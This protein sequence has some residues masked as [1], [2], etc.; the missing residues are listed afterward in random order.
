MDDP[1]G[2]PRRT[3][4]DRL[5]RGTL[6][7]WALALIVSMMLWV[8]AID[9]RT[10]TVI[11]RLPLLAPDLPAGYAL[12]PET[13][14]DSVLVSFSGRG[15]G[16]LWDQITGRPESVRLTHMP[17][18]APGMVPYTVLRSIA[19]ED[20]RF[21]GRAYA[22]LDATAFEPVAVPLTIDRESTRRIPIKV[23]SSGEIPAR[24]YWQRSSSDSVTVTGA[25]TVI[26]SLDSC[27]TLGIGPGPDD[28]TSEIPAM[29]GVLA[30]D[31]ST[32]SVALLPPVPVVSV[33][34]DPR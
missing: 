33:P 3:L 11:H 9:N 4:L 30:C 7:Q 22:T 6:L 13:W 25:A 31:P 15:I 26:E 8:A 16:V 32:A 20:V 12:L 10:F 23:M 34:P 27:R 1:R 19:P 17:P 28:R 29:P 2:A 21:A 18:A 5:S 24:Y 14:S